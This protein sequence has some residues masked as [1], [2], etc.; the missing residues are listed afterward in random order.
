MGVAFRHCIFVNNQGDAG[1]EVD[2][3]WGQWTSWA[4]CSL[5]CGGGVT[6]RIRNI[7]VEASNGGEKCIGERLETKECQTQ[8]CPDL[9]TTTTTTST[10]T[11]SCAQRGC[12]SSYECCPNYL[13][14]HVP[15]PC[16]GIGLDCKRCVLSPP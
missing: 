2:C 8:Q 6:A 11:T 10:T 3:L 12:F 14:R 9:T 13:C 7:S 1:A 4:V 5:S 16:T 15:E